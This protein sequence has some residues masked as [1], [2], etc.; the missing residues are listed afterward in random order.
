MIKPK[1]ATSPTILKKYCWNLWR[2]IVYLQ[3]NHKCLLC[4]NNLDKG[5]RLNPHHLISKKILKYMYEPMNG[6]TLCTYCHNFSPYCSPHA[7][8]WCFEDALKELKPEQYDWWVERRVVEKEKQETP[9]YTK[10]FLNL[11]INHWYGKWG[12]DKE[13][14]YYPKFENSNDFKIL[15]KALKYDIPGIVTDTS[16][17]AKLLKKFMRHYKIKL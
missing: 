16:E 4:D 1:Y 6:I 3:D 2:D 17:D 13:I 8:A 14:K 10:I 9:E 11:L 5:V 12:K 15:K 7:A